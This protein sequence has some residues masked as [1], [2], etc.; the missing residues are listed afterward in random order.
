MKGIVDEMGD[1]IIMQRGGDFIVFRVLS[2]DCPGDSWVIDAE[3]VDEFDT[4]DA[5]LAFVSAQRASA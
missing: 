4:H 2:A 1:L 3:Y 5:A